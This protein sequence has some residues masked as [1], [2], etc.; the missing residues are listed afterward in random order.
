[1]NFSSITLILALAILPRLCSGAITFNFTYEDVDSGLNFGFDDPAE[2]AIR[3]ATVAAVGDYLNTVLDENGVADI[4]W[5]AS[6]DDPFSSNLAAMGSFFFGDQG[7]D[8]GLVFKH[9]TTGVDPTSSALDGA[10]QINFG[11]NWNSDHTA[12]TGP[13]EFDLFTVVLHEITHALGVNSL[14]DVT[15]GS[16]FGG[17]YSRFDT[18]LSGP[19]GNFLTGSTFTGDVA[20]FTSGAVSFASTRGDL[21][22]F[23][24]DP[25]DEGS[26]ISHLAFTHNALMNPTI[27]EGVEKREYTIEDLA[28]LE[29]IGY[30]IVPE[31]NGVAL[32]LVSSMGL[33]LRR[34]R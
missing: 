17:T 20:D 29:T 11:Q 30:N 9:I 14:I 28:L 24:P 15:D 5:N 3:R 18:F 27:S 1:M 10:G 32:L 21:D 2:G 34:R 4:R 33:L 22:I 23:S 26:S 8:D 25:F 13:L 12:T 19:N 6:T 7:I 16:S 31:P